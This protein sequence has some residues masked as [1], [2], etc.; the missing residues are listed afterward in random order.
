MN[1]NPC[2]DRHLLEQAM[3]VSGES[4]ASTVL[5]RA[6][7]EFIARRSPKRILE[8]MGKLEWDE[9]YDRKRERSR[10]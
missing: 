6:L 8:L 1:D 7:E 5:T 4:D 2:V 3:E 10:N 9:S